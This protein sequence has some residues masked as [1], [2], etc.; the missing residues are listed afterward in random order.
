MWGVVEGD[1]TGRALSRP[2]PHQRVQCPREVAV[3]GWGN[4]NGALDLSDRLDPTHLDSATSPTPILQTLCALGV[5]KVWPAQML[6]EGEKI[7]IKKIYI[8][9]AA[10]VQTTERPKPGTKPTRSGW[11]PG[12]HEPQRRRQLSRCLAPTTLTAGGCTRPPPPEHSRKP[13]AP[14]EVPLTTPP[15]PGRQAQTPFSLRQGESK[16]WGGALRASWTSWLGA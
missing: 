5:E 15:L 9:K 6:P 8:Y 13:L 12:R 4:V 2:H 10:C 1:S 14:A 16:S 11:I 7:A 3:P